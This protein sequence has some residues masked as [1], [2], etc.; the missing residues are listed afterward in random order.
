MD[1]S[2][3]NKGISSLSYPPTFD[4]GDMANI[5]TLEADLGFADPV[6]VKFGLYG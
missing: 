6:N 3:A 1:S 2:I 4:D 5:Q